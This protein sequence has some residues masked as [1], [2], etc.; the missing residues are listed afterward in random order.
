MLVTCQGLCRQTLEY[1]FFTQSAHGT[2]EAWQPGNNLLLEVE[3]DAGTV[4]VTD[5]WEGEP[6]CVTHTAFL[7]Y[8]SSRCL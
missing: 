3:D 8:R 4:L 6:F 2:L 1:K 5:N 7:L